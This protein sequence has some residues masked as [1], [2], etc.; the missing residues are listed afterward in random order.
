MDSKKSP[1]DIIAIIIAM[2][3]TIVELL[4]KNFEK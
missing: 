4:R 3:S 2:A 1:W